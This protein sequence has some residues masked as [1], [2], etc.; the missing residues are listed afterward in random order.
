MSAATNPS[1]DGG[2]RRSRSGREMEAWHEPADFNWEKIVRESQ[3]DIT[4]WL[5]TPVASPAQRDAMGCPL[6]NEPSDEAWI[7][8][9]EDTLLDLEANR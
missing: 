2:S 4:H 6:P 3:P 8:V 1:D 5:I 7:L 9:E